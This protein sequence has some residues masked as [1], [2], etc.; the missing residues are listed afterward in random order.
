[1]KQQLNRHKLPNYTLFKNIV[2]NAIKITIGDHSGSPALQTGELIKNN[3][4][5]INDL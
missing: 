1:M 5:D 3:Q 2:I 4:Y